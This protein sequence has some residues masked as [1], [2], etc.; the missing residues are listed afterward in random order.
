MRYNVPCPHPA[1]RSTVE[2]GPGVE[3]LP[4]IDIYIPTDGTLAAENRVRTQAAN[5]VPNAIINTDR[6]PVDSNLETLFADLSRIISV[7]ALL[8][9]LMGAVGFTA[10]IIGGLLERRRPFALLRATGMRIGELRWV[11]LLE[12]SVTMVVT[13]TAGVGLGLALAYTDSTRDGGVWSWPAIEVFGYAGAGV[14]AALIFSTFALPLLGAMTR[15]DAIR[16][17]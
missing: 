17:E 3:D 10:G 5:L 11:V 7:A 4:I 12:T 9:L 15:H 13:S 2:P 6:D 16:Y 14:L 1:D 8:V